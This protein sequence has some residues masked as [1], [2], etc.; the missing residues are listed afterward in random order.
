MSAAPPRVRRGWSVP[1]GLE[2]E[3]RV[4]L[5]LVAAAAAVFVIA[6]LLFPPFPVTFDEAKYLGIGFSLLEGLGPRNVFGDYFILR[7]P[8]PSP[9]TRWSSGGSS[10]R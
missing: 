10:T 8:S 2:S 4:S 7:L 3:A 5:A 1:P 9:P 6:L